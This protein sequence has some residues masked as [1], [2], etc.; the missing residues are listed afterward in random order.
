[1]TS[2]SCDWAYW[3]MPTVAVSPSCFTH[4]W[5]SPNRIPPRSGIVTPFPSFRMRPLVERQRNHFRRSGCATHVHANTGPRLGQGRRHVGHPDVVAKREGDIARGH[6]PYRPTVFDDRIAVTGNIAIEHFEAHEVSAE[7]PLASL[8]DGVAAD[9]VLVEAECPIQARLEWIR[10]GVDVIA[11]EAHPGFQAQGVPCPE[12]GWPNAIGPTRIEQ[13]PPQ[14]RR[15]TGAAEQL[16]TVFTRVTRSRNQARH[17]RD[18]ALDEGVVLPAAELGCR[19][20]LHQANGSWALHADQRPFTPDVEDR[21]APTLPSDPVEVGALVAGIDHQPV[22]TIRDRIGKDIIDDATCLVAEHGVLNPTGPQPREVTR[23]DSLGEA[24]VLDPQLAHVR[25][26]EQ[27]HSFPHRAMFLADAAVL[28]RHDPA[29]EVG[30]LGAEADV[31]VVERCPLS[32]H[33]QTLR[34]DCVAIPLGRLDRQERRGSRVA[35]GRA[36]CA[37][38]P[39]S[40]G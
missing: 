35:P 1:M 24:L 37:L 16:E 25:Q 26:I 38:R 19:Q 5:V 27:P 21:V 6:G 18:L 34:L 2:P 28:E 36:S 23:D 29:T 40:R 10:A 31:F 22:A 17:I 14:R 13:R 32:R 33:D 15:V 8:H 30:H 4:S 3:L 11:M 7:P 9:E 20:P 12:A 39:A